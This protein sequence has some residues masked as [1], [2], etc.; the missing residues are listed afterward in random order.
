[1]ERA[2][3]YNGFQT[4]QSNSIGFHMMIK[5]ALLR[6]RVQRCNMQSGGPYQIYLL[7]RVCFYSAFRCLLPLSAVSSGRETVSYYVSYRAM[8]RLHSALAVFGWASLHFASYGKRTRNIALC[9]FFALVFTGEVVC[10]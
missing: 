7:Y 5:T 1:L 10:A 9:E 3:E 2:Y 8:Y 6:G 4:V